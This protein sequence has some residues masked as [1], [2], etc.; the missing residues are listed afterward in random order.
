MG[1][2]ASTLRAEEFANRA[3]WADY[4]YQPREASTYSGVNVTADTALSSSPVW[5]AIQL[6]SNSVGMTPIIL[7]RRLRDG[8]KERATD[9][10]IYD[11]LHDSPNQWQTA[12][13]WVSM[14]M[15]HALLWGNGYSL[16]EPGQRGPVD[17][18]IPLHPDG[19][20]VERL[21]NNRGRRYMVRQEDGTWKAI[22]DE[23][24]FHLPGLS[25]DGISGLSIMRYARESIGLELAAKRHAALA[26]GQGTRLSGIL[27]I[28]GSLSKEAKD[29][30]LESWQDTKG[31]GANAYKSAVLDDQADWIQTGMNNEDAQLLEQLNWSV[32][33]TARYINVPLHMIQH[34]TP[35][36]SW[37]TGIESIKNGYVT[38]SVMPW[39]VKWQARIKKDLITANRVYFA[40][41]LLDSLL[42][43]DTLTRYQAYQIA[44]GGNNSPGWMSPN[45][46]RQIENMN[47]EPGGDEINR[48]PQPTPTS[49]P[50]ALGA[51][52]NLSLRLMVREAA[53]RLAR[54]ET[55][56]MEKADRKG[57]DDPG[58]W[59]PAVMAFYREHA[60]RLSSV[61]GISSGAAASYCREQA[62]RLGAGGFATWLDDEA[63]RIDRLASLALEVSP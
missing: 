21:P 35:S 54:M 9:H 4:W 22:N 28:K 23:D 50:A 37:G 19:V 13:E 3:P 12:P 62:D 46:V 1:L 2:L 60:G 15:V 57:L 51:R 30:L 53:A 38:F 32:E 24:V 63:Y 45:Q 56:A 14:M 25:I 6:Q 5:A 20:R 59:G 31:G 55:A 26:F 10:P 11:L 42:R 61:L 8:G 47:P 44:L 48:G 40:E 27:K 49:P 18:L 43:G 33:D 7:Y 39:T 41:F 34:T 16:I 58:S 36:T 52:D 29:R 17:Q